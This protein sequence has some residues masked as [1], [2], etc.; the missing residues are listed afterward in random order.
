MHL[1]FFVYLDTMYYLVCMLTIMYPFLFVLHLKRIKTFKGQYSLSCFGWSV[2][3][4][5]IYIFIYTPTTIKL[6]PLNGRVYVGC[7]DVI[8]LWGLFICWLWDLFIWY[9]SPFVSQ[10]TQN[11]HY[12]K[13]DRY[14]QMFGAIHTVNQYHWYLVASGNTSSL[15]L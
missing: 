8:W 4:M 7:L 10:E 13:P 15:I 6:I 2:L 1:L 14:Y 3:F 12:A 9:I 11:F 5:T